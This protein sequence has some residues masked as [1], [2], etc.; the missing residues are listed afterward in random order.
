VERIQGIPR[1]FCCSG[2]ETVCVGVSYMT[3]DGRPG[4]TED[5]LIEDIPFLALY[6]SA[7]SLREHEDLRGFRT[8]KLVCKAS[9]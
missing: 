3:T 7:H 5:G 2:N 6:L 9:G 1:R 4:S 8:N